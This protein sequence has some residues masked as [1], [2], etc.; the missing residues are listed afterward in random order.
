VYG[1][2]ADSTAKFIA[3]GSSISC[4]AVEGLTYL[5][6]ILDGRPFIGFRAMSQQDSPGEAGRAIAMYHARYPTSMALY[7]PWSY[8]VERAAQRAIEYGAQ[9]ILMPGINGAE[10]LKYI[11]HIGQR[12]DSGA[13]IPTTVEEHEELLW[14]CASTSPFWQLQ[15]YPDKPCY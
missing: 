3:E 15:A 8:N 2:F 10:M 11:I 1:R 6:D 9:G 4:V 14:E 5:A 12:T 13:P 7:S